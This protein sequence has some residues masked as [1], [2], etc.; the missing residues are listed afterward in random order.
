MGTAAHSVSE[1]H[2]LPHLHFPFRHF[3][4]IKMCVLSPSPQAVIVHLPKVFFSNLHVIDFWIS[5]WCLRSAPQGLSIRLVWGGKYR[6]TSFFLQ[7]RQFV[8]VFLTH[9]PSVTVQS[10]NR[11][12]VHKVIRTNQS[13]IYWILSRITDGERVTLSETWGFLNMELSRWQSQTE[14]R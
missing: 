10:L 5:L 3:R 12:D 13:M 6:E 11:K 9:C 7:W 4:I 2:L 14:W 1:G 8:I